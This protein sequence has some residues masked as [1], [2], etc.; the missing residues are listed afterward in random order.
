VFGRLPAFLAAALAAVVLV[1]CT[2]T[3]AGNP[4]RD[5]TSSGEVELTTSPEEQPNSNDDL[6]SDGAPKVTDPLD[7]SHFEE[8]PCDV[9]NADQAR[10][11]NVD[12]QGERSDTSF[13]LGCRWQSAESNG[14]TSINFMS[15][16]ERGLSSTYRSYEEGEF[17]YFEPIADIEGQP[18]VALHPEDKNPKAT[19]AIVVGLTDELAFMNITNL[20]SNNVG[21]KDPCESAVTA[22]TFMVQTIK[23]GR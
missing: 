18:A 5:T 11:L 20:S 3:A 15:K 16:D 17:Q 22:M 14:N 8:N 6:P 7:A 9:L 19:C 21:H 12:G 4:V 23:A 2:T 13:G 10:Q 1:A